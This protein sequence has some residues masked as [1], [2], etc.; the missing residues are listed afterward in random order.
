M[1][2]SAEFGVFGGS[3]FYTFIENMQEVKVDTPYGAPSSLVAIGEYKGRKIAFLPRHG[4]SHEFPPHKVPYRANVW[5]MKELGVKRIIAPTAVGSLQREYEMG[6]FVV[7]DQFVDMTS[8]RECT[9]YEGPVTTHISMAEPYC[10]ELRQIAIQGLERLGIKF[11][12]TGTVVVVQGPRFSTK[13]ESVWFTNNGWHTINMTQYPE[14]VLARELEMCYVNIG[15][16]TDYDVGLVAE[17]TVQAV[18]QEMV[19]KAFNENI[20]KLKEL[21]KYIVETTPSKC[22]CNCCNSLKDA[23]VGE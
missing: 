10:P 1:K 3:G 5:A 6:D 18:S 23:R 17:G 4:K 21:I 14:V 12:P 20:G 11:H 13:A 8:G 7:T 16:I 15:V 19:I 2:H 22:S 9:F